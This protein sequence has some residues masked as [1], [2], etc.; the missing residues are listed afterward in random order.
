MVNV[1]KCIEVA[2]GEIETEKEKAII[3][4]IKVF[5]KHISRL[6]EELLQAKKDYSIFI[7]KTKNDSI[8]SNLEA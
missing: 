7:N 2:I 4:R 1:N 3:E 5:K 6:E 8:K